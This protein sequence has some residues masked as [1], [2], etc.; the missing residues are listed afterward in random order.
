[1]KTAVRLLLAFTFAIVCGI[2]FASTSTPFQRWVKCSSNATQLPSSAPQA[3]YGGWRIQN[4]GAKAVW[5]GTSSSV[6][7]GPN[8][9]YSLVNSNGGTFLSNL[10]NPNKLWCIDVSGTNGVSVYGEF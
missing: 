7:A 9:T 1:M 5:V 3:L 8:S 6:T 2:A 10:A 4:W